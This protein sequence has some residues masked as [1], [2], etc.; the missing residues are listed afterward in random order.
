MALPYCDTRISTLVI[1]QLCAHIF[2]SQDAQFASKI[3]YDGIELTQ[4]WPASW[5]DMHA[6]A[7]PSLDGRA[8]LWLHEAYAREAKT[9]PITE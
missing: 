8:V 2:Y 7:L 9:L 3:D 4:I 6:I 1:G 5:L